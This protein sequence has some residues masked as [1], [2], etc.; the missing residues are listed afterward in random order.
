M[1]V[2]L[3]EKIRME[4]QKV[5]DRIAAKEAKA[6]ELEALKASLPSRVVLPCVISGRVH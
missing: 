6:A 5:A 4:A 3:Q 2:D 1:Q